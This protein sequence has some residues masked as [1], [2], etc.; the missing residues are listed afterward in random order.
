MA[1]VLTFKT[2]E[3]SKTNDVKTPFQVKFKRQ[4]NQGW[5][6]GKEDDITIAIGIVKS[7]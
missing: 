6:K 2:Y 1:D 3:R 7:E 4:L 5:T